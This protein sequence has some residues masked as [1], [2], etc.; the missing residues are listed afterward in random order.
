MVIFRCEK[1]FEVL[2]EVSAV[3]CALG[4]N[5]SSAFDL[6][7]VGRAVDIDNA[8]HI[9]IRKMMERF[10]TEKIG[11]RKRHLLDYRFADYVIMISPFC[12][13]V[14]GFPR[15]NYQIADFLY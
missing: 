12:L 14:K 6:G 11:I 8:C 3:C 15:K 9:L 10:L 13:Y 4:S 5:E 2:F 1:E 7:F